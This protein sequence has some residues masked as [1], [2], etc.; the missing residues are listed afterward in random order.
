MKDLKITI[1]YRDQ[2]LELVFDLNVMEEI[3]GEYGSF[4]K[5]AELS[6][7]DPVEIRDDNGVVIRTE[8]PEPDIKALLFGFTAMLN[9]GID[10]A[11]DDGGK[12]PMLTSKQVGRIITEVGLAKANEAL[13]RAV[14]ASITTEDGK[15]A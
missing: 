8:Q 5:W 1:P 13:Q 7:P 14:S 12:R 15:N 4:A 6:S 9:E 3:Q 10:I 2:T 11:N